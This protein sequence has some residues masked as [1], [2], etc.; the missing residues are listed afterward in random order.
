MAN[1]LMVD[2]DADVAEMMAFVLERAGHEVRRA[3]D[4]EDGLRILH[5]VHPDV[6]VLDVEMPRLT[7]P[8]MVRRILLQDAGTE[9]IPVVLVSGVVELEA[10]ARRVGVPY[11]LVKPCSAD[12]LRR[13]VDLALRERLPLAR[14][15]RGTPEEV[16]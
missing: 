1:V 4:G 8:E 10:L 14:A 5:E 13:T 12:A 6:I 7:G 11:S 9:K 2:D 3:V 16:R 15:G